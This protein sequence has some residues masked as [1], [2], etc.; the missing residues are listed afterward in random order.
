[1]ISNYLRHKL[2]NGLKLITAPVSGTEAVTILVLLPVGS[3]YETKRLNGVSHFIE[4]M[5]FKG[6]KKRPSNLLIAKELDAIGAEYNAFTGKDLTGYW[7]K[8]DKDYLEIGLEILAD[9]LFNSL[10]DKNEFERERSVILEEIKMY[11]DNP[12]FY[13]DDLFEQTL[14]HNHPLGWS[15]SGSM[16]SVKKISH[17][18]L[19]KFKNEYYQVNRMLIT[20]AGN[21]KTEKARRLIKKF[22]SQASLLSQRKRVFKKYLIKKQEKYRLN[23]LTK[24]IQQ[25]QLALGFPAYSFFH[26]KIEALELLSIILGGNMS[27]R[28]FTE[29]RVKR[30]LAYFIKT[31]LNVYQDTGNFVIRAGVDQGKLKKAIWVIL[32]ELKK[33]RD[34]GLGKE[35]L[36]RAKNFYE[37]KLSLNL[38]DSAEMATWYARQEMLMGRILSPQEKVVKIKKVSVKDIEAVSHEIIKPKALNLAL[39]GPQ[40]INRSSLLSIFRKEL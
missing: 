40:N 31:D 7:I 37:G 9:I 23:I 1:M 4:H 15:I 12:L 26:P 24:D 38:E 16:E 18:D 11:Q 33:I 28:L 30:G 36:I 8:L 5:I 32:K 20:I 17:Q 22:F 14:Y 34:Q 21:V 2:S 29:V 19:L 6:T 27:S 25:V 39:I 10:F 13:I 3:R 35:E